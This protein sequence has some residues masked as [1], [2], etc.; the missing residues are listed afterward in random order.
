MTQTTVN[1]LDSLAAA[2]ASI[3]ARLA[4]LEAVLARYEPLVAEAAR[5]MAGPLR[6]QKKER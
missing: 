5:R 1:D 3:D 2:L 6:W 4:H